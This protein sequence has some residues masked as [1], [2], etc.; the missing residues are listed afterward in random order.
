MFSLMKYQAIDSFIFTD[1]V[2][3]DLL[4]TKKRRGYGYEHQG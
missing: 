1:Y 3:N 4:I 2:R